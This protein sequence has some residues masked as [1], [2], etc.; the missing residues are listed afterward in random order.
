MKV[1]SACL[2]HRTEELGLRPSFGWSDVDAPRGKRWRSTAR[3]SRASPGPG[4]EYQ[5][6]YSV[7]MVQKDWRLVREASV[8]CD[9]PYQVCAIKSAG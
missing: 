4:T 8:Y 3:R 1:S 2:A 7:L 6:W 5:V 9:T